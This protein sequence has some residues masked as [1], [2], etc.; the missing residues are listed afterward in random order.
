[1]STGTTIHSE[2]RLATDDK[3][4]LTGE[5]HYKLDQSHIPLMRYDKTRWLFAHIPVYTKW[6][7][8][9]APLPTLTDTAVPSSA[10]QAVPLLPAVSPQ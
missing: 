1:M 9:I 2:N 6:F 7:L 8:L 10:G 3:H 5:I 4:V